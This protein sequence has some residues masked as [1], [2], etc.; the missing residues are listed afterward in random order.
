ML[1]GS[2][3]ACLETCGDGKNFGMFHCDDSN[4]KDGDG[5]SKDCVVEKDF[6]CFG[7]YPYLAD[8]CSYIQTTIE[9]LTVN[10]YNDIIVKF[11]RP[12]F[13]VN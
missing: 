3:G 13:I 7:G 11:T 1:V 5:C 10:Q 9:S 8:Q 2:S 4:Q 6:T 12:I